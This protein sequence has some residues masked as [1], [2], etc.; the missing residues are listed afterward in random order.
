ME[1]LEL[2]A[3]PIIVPSLVLPELDSLLCEH[4]GVDAELDFLDSLANGELTLE[5]VTEA[6]LVRCRNLIAQ[7]RSLKIGMTDAA[8]MTVAERLGVLRILTV[9]LRDLRAVVSASGRPF[10]LVPWD[11]QA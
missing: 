6:D 2:E 10:F 5:Q 4:L 11:T 1:A 9:D 3:G 8:V 7:Y